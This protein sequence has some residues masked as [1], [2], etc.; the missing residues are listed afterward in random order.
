MIKS[1]G[2]WAS[3]GHFQGPLGSRCIHWWTSPLSDRSIKWTRQAQQA[4]HA[5]DWPGAGRRDDRVPP[6]R[7]GARG[8]HHLYQ[9]RCHSLYIVSL[10]GKVRSLLL[11]CVTKNETSEFSLLMNSWNDFVTPGHNETEKKITCWENE[12]FVEEYTT[13]WPWDTQTDLS[14][15]LIKAI[16]CLFR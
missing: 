2:Q 15:F 13:L 10:D 7:D 6:V 12:N 5:P 8:G 9:G 3:K 16:F 1:K 14:L 11:Y 4:P